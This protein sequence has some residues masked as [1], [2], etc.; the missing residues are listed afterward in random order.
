MKKVKSLVLGSALALLVT[1]GVVQA[2]ENWVGYNKDVGAFNGSAYTGYVGMTGYLT[3]G[4]RIA[5]VSSNVGGDYTVDIRAQRSGGID[6]N[7]SWIRNVGDNVKGSWERVYLNQEGEGYRLQFS[8]D[9]ST[10]VK[11]N[12]TGT[13]KTY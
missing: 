8:N 6:P 11:V 3:T 10:P 9:L 13:F 12:V 7:T 4:E 2:G 1:G 5:F